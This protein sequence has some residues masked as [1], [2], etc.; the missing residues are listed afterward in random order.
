MATM[1]TNKQPLPAGMI[2]INQRSP[3]EQRAIS[4]KGGSRSTEAKKRAGKL[5]WIKR[6]IKLGR[7]KDTD[8]EWLLER[9]ENPE[10]MS[11]DLL[12][13]CDEIRHTPNLAPQTKIKLGALYSS[14]F[15]TMHGEHH[16]VDMNVQGNLNINFGNVHNE[17]FKFID[18]S[19][20]D[21]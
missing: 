15:K 10:L 5:N 13:F 19:L 21:K 17:K 8:E 2:P 20:E 9:V 4:S 1:T 6:Q 7:L 11:M 16:K 12:N 14:A 3:E 18:T